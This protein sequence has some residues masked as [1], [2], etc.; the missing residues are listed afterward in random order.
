[1]L[2]LWS[3]MI[4][5]PKI[6]GVADGSSTA[7]TVSFLSEIKI[8]IVLLAWWCHLLTIE[9]NYW[10]Y[11]TLTSLFYIVLLICNLLVPYTW[12]SAGEVMKS[13]HKCYAPAPLWDAVTDR[14]H[15]AKE[16][17]VEPVWCTDIMENKENSNTR[18]TWIIPYRVTVS[19]WYEKCIK[20]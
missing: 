7:S 3:S 19:I 11:K 8:K 6:Q 5:H 16:R 14:N 18:D 20:M 2:Y 17:V 10:V 1:M 13:I 15:N 9:Q 4:N 12:K